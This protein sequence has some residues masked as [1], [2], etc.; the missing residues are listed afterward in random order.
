MNE[1]R[2]S[3]FR[4]ER[5]QRPPERGGRQVLKQRH[6]R[7]LLKTNATTNNNSCW[8][9]EQ[10][11]PP[12]QR[13][14]HRQEASSVSFFGLATS[15]KENQARETSTFCC[16]RTIVIEAATQPSPLSCTCVS[17]VP[18]IAGPLSFTSAMNSFFTSQELP[19][20]I[21]EHSCRYE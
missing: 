17:T 18:P 15:P 21:Q 16:L 2:N 14:P 20:I 13:P 1:R 9:L 5:T 3:L 19:H 6:F 8:T 12:T 11:Q 7:V 4:T 10:Q